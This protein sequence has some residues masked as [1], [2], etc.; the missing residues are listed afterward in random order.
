MFASFVDKRRLRSSALPS[1]PV[2]ASPLHSHSTGVSAVSGSGP[3]QNPSALRR[4]ASAHPRAP[5]VAAHGGG[6]T[7]MSSHT[8]SH[9][10]L[11]SFAPSSGSG[12][13]SGSGSGSTVIGGGG[14]SGSGGGGGHRSVASLLSPSSSA[15]QHHGAAHGAS[16]SAVSRHNSHYN[17]HPRDQP[18]R[19]SGSM[20]SD[21]NTSGARPPRKRTR[22]TNA[23][24]RTRSAHPS[25][26]PSALSGMGGS[27]H[28]VPPPPPP[29]SSVTSRSRALSPAGAGASG[30]GSVSSTQQRSFP[31]DVCGSVFAQRGQL[32]RHHRRV[33]EKLRPHACE[34]CGKLFGAR[35]D[36]TRH[37]QVSSNQSLTVHELS[38]SSWR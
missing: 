23:L 19:G 8:G 22:T 4:A 16:S 31:C 33:H 3:C 30:S 29:H 20:V 17:H 26:N 38:L 15:P 36:R 5:P 28:V 11:S 34:Y 13:A 24:A 27:G 10:H 35:S 37:V 6:H 21:D 25:T 18:G 7:S 12:S 32:S 9:G 14:G 2:S 1:S